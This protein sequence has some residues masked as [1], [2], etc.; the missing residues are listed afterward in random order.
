MHPRVSA[1]SVATIGWP[2]QG[3]RREC[4]GFRRELDGKVD[5]KLSLL[6]PQSLTFPGQSSSSPHSGQPSPTKRRFSRN[7]T[8]PR[9]FNDGS[10]CILDERL[11]CRLPSMTVLQFFDSFS[12]F[13]LELKSLSCPRARGKNRERARRRF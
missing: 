8:R 3:G 4:P 6:C 7:Q 12:R 13:V 5:S 9:C 11:H 1:R 2:Y 10:E